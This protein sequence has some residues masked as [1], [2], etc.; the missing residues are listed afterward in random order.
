MFCDIDPKTMLIDIEKLEEILKV[1]N[2]DLITIVSFAGYPIEHRKLS[3]IA[4]KYGCKIIEDAC[5][6]PGSSRVYENEIVRTGSC[7]YVDVTV[8]SFHPV[9]HIACGEGG[10]ITTNCEDVY[11]KLCLLR[12]HG[13]SNK[14]LKFK[15]NNDGLWYHEQHELGYNY[16]MPDILAALGNSQLMRLRSSIQKRNEIAV[17]Y[18]KH[19]RDLP[20]TVPYRENSIEHAFHLYVIRTERRKELYEYLRSNKIFAQVHYL[21][22]YLHPYYREKYGCLKGQFP[23][24]EKFYDECLSLPMFPT[25]SSI[26][27]QYV[28]SKIIEFCN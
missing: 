19:L 13:I 2:I 14:E 4:K 28:I 1:E 9:K 24:V 8:F 12:T 6:S 23:V 26:D 20:L 3:E 7:D 16:R 21:P 17:I 27:Q 10:M 22:V 15:T 18:D 5:H 25:L 11:E